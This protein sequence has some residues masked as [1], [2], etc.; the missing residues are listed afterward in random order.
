MIDIANKIREKKYDCLIES[1]GDIDVIDALRDFERN[2]SY[3]IKTIEEIGMEDWFLIFYV[4]LIEQD[5]SNLYKL[6]KQG[7]EEMILDA[8]YCEGNIETLYSKMSKSSK[9]YFNKFDNI[10][11]LNYDNII[12]KATGCTTFHLHGDFNTKKFR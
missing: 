1:Y 10:F 12:E 5:I 9:D 6:V 7:L 8:I 4:Y 2:H 3:E 11:T